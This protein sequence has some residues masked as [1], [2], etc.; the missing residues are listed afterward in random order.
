MHQIDG[1][2][3]LM[4]II[5]QCVAKIKKIIS[6]NSST[7]SYYYYY[8]YSLSQA[9]FGSPPDVHSIGE[10]PLRLVLDRSEHN[11]AYCQIT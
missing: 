5:Q 2:K 10:I 11:E 7:T 9:E 3:I 8:H 1:M 6:N 4:M